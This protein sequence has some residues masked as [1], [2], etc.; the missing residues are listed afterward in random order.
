M[1]PLTLSYRTYELHKKVALAISRGTASS[2]CAVIIKLESQGV[3]G[4]G[5]A[6]EF[7]IPGHE[8]KRDRI[9]QD[10][11]AAKTIVAELDPMQRAVV[12]QALKQAN[13]GSSVRNAI[14]MALYDWA[15]K[16]LG[17][18][19]WKLLGLS[20]TPKAPI[21]VTIGISSPEAA[22]DRL[23]AWQAQG[24]IRG[25][26]VKL[27]SP[28][29]VDADK[30]M[31][32]AIRQHVSDDAYIG[33]DANGGWDLE[34]SVMMSAW[35]H[36]RGVVH[37]EQPLAPEDHENFSELYQRSSLPI[38]LDESCCSAQDVQRF[39]G[40]CHGINIKLTKCGGLTEALRMIAVAQSL[41]LSTMVGC[42]G[43]T[44][45]GNAAAHHLASMIDFIDLDSHLNLL[46]DP[47]SGMEFNDGYLL[48]SQKPGLGI[49]YDER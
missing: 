10:L 26:K 15:G 7:D 44:C 45:L 20:P 12:E 11:E 37:M 49:D 24:K 17:V 18:P 23:K 47:T 36:E 1:K 16:K 2:S 35:L 27:G 40:C 8:E 48:N 38:F 5:E 4:L 9:L 31:L 39:Y 21:S 46:D 30:S 6:A 22:I 41:G 13:I 14:D 3:I 32:D 34:R 42:Y 29:G 19:I 28:N 43:N 25:V 33:I